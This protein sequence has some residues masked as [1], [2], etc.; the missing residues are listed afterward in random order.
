MLSSVCDAPIETDILEF[1]FE[2][3]NQEIY[4][5]LLLSNYDIIYF[6]TDSESLDRVGIILEM[7][8]KAVPTKVLVV[9]G[10]E[11]SFDTDQYMMHNPEI[12]F[13]FR[14]ENEEILYNFVKT[15]LEYKFDFESIPGLGYRENEEPVINRVNA[16]LEFGEIPFPYEISNILEDEIAYYESRR[17]NPDRCIYSQFFTESS[18]KERSIGTICTELRYFLVKKYKRVDV[19]DTWFNYNSDR[20][21]RIW[22]FLINNDNGAT[23]FEFNVNGYMLDDE[24][25][26]LLSEA[27]EGEFIFNIDV[28]SV[29]S[30][31][32]EACNRKENSYQL[33]YNVNKLLQEGN[34]RVNVTQKIGLPLE[35]MNKFSKSF[36]KIYGIGA[37]EIKYEILKIERGTKLSKDYNKYG[38]KFMKNYPNEI[39]SSDFMNAKE[40]IKAFEIG[41]LV[42]KINPKKNFEFS[43]PRIFNDTKMKPFQFFEKLLIF[44]SNNKLEEKMN[45]K[46]DSYRI[47]YEFATRVY[48]DINDTLKLPIIMEILRSDMENVSTENEINSFDKQGFSLEY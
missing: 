21:Y 28:D 34:I 7:L 18:L 47:I 31:V 45:D 26:N 12:D 24:T 25:I 32:L 15:I 2:E 38:Y 1:D 39:I 43:I 23:T 35:D 33:L 36:N 4:K 20:A 14:G 30:E 5:T 16:S 37:D 40:I 41:N 9:G 27:R 42:K 17:G 46:M 22:E 13:V 6:H 19:L 10:M 48:D 11:V 29:N 8:K 3:S 44:I